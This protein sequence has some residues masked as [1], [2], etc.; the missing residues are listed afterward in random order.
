MSRG[1]GR[2]QR[3]VVNQVCRYEFLTTRVASVHLWVEA[4]APSISRAIASLERKGY[5]LRDV[6]D[7]EEVL[8]A[9]SKGRG[10]WAKLQGV[11]I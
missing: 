5:M 2:V 11:E 6:E 3:D 10:A 9:T 7:G 8:K 1:L 4:P